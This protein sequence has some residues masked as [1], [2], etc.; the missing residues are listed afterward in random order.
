MEAVLSAVEIVLAIFLMIGVGILLT[1][2]GW[3]SDESAPLISRLTVHVA[4]PCTILNNV[5][6]YYTR[7]SLVESGLGILIS[8]VMILL[9]MGLGLVLARLLKLEKRRRGAFVCMFCMSNS[10]FIGLPVCRA[11]FGEA[12]VPSALMYYIANTTVFWS[13]GNAMMRQDDDKKVPM[14]TMV[15]RM[16][17]TPLKAF[18]ISAVLV[19]LGVTLPGFIMKA[20]GYI[21]NMVTPLSLIYTGIIVM[22]MIRRGRVKWEKG[23]FTILAGRFLVAPAAMLGLCMLTGVSDMMRSVL[24]LQAAMPVMAQTSI[25]A[26]ELGADEEYSAGGITITTALSMLFIPLFMMLLSVIG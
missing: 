20:S 3:L 10:I 22:R 15:N 16:I 2:I 13:L 25:V 26:A 5:M 24:V 17:P 7:E 4:L 1:K 18:L 21:G 12:A 11:L 9:A 23:Y 14:K 6:T 8:Y 19:L